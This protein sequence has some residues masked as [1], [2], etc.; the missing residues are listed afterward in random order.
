MTGDLYDVLGGSYAASLLMTLQRT[1]LLERLRRPTRVE[2]LVDGV[3]ETTGLHAALTFLAT[4]TTVLTALDDGSFELAPAYRTYNGLGFH[5][6]KFLGGYGAAVQ[7]LG[8]P[9]TGPRADLVDRVAL[10]RA[11]AGRS[12]S[13]GTVM[14]SVL[15][16]WSV[17]ALV[18]L[19][20]GPGAL[21]LELASADPGF[22]GWGIDANPALV[23]AAT[24]ASLDAGVAD[25]VGF[26]VGDV[27]DVD[28][29]VPDGLES[30]AVHAGSL[31]NEFF[32]RGDGAAVDVL[33]T[34]R[35]RFADRVI[36]VEDYY[37]RLGVAVDADVRHARLQDLAQVAS[38][39]GLPPP[40]AEGWAAVYA[41]AG[42]SLLHRYEA[43]DDGI[44]WFIHVCRLG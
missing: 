33:T 20:C 16:A 38:G 13:A 19:G 4:S 7:A 24:A 21:L 34:I 9:E 5:L 31:L 18:D 23:A 14:A 11:F 28:A 2:D 10:A 43:T 44:A 35:G 37:G 1:G 40:D 15:Q 32:A 30:A 3:D 39:Q 12:A 26:A 6:D 27:R 8:A 29:V 17:D 36:F 22:R 41:A 25:R 42:C